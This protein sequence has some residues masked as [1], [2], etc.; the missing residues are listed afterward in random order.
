M[1]PS[2]QDIVHTDGADIFETEDTS[3]GMQ[4]MTEHL[5]HGG[6]ENFYQPTLGDI[7]QAVQKC[8]ASVDD[9]KRKDLAACGREV[10][11][12][13]QDLQKIREGT[14]VVEGKIRPLLH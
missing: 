5:Q 7:L 2:D 1:S 10:S 12:L 9:Q 8:K 6:N 3:G 13:C 11:L 4:D 14:T